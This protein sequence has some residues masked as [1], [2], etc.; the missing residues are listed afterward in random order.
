MIRFVSISDLNYS[1]IRTLIGRMGDHFTRLLDDSLHP[2]WNKLLAVRKLFGKMQE[3]DW[4]FWMDAD[5]VIMQEFDP[6]TLTS[7]NHN[8]IANK[9]WNGMCL[10]NFLIRKCEWSENLIDTLL[11]LGES[12]PKGV[13]QNLYS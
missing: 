1:K 8:L 13:L 6:E 5:S 11:F 3:N 2:S 12:Y 9:D 4:V 10:S 7:P